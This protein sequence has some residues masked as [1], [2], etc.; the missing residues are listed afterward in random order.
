MPNTQSLYSDLMALADNEAFYFRDFVKGDRTY[1]IFSYRLASYT[2]FLAPNAL[3]CRGI[4]YDVTNEP[5][6]VSRPMEKFFNLYENPLTMDLDLSTVVGIELKA[7]GSLISTYMHNDELMLKSKASLNSDQALAAMK[8]LA[9]PESEA[10]HDEL[11]SVALLGNTVNLEWCAP[12]NRIV[13]AYMEPVLTVLNI[14]NNDSGEYLSL[15]N[16][17]HTYPEIEKR[18]VDVV[19]VDEDPVDFVNSIT[20]MKGVE[21]Y[22]VRLASGQRVK[23]KTEWYFAQHLERVLIYSPRCLFEAVL[24]ETTDDLRA[25]FHRDQLVIKQIDEME[26]KVDSVYNHLVDQVDR[27]YERNKH[28]RRKEYAILGQKELDRKLL[29]LAMSKYLGKDVDYK[30]FLKK[31]YRGF[32]I[33]DDSIESNC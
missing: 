15:N 24:E 25:Q 12:D 21:G 30:T 26:Q 23:I 33:L 7:D 3:E 9:R 27:F 2:D 14:R 22:V 17:T 31:H 18:H 16:I 1:R 8:W 28:M 32:G 11:H 13:I 20:S 4:M 29:N 10:F 6:L 5:V 19:D